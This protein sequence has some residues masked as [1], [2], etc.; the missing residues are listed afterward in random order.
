[1]IQKPKLLSF[2]RDMQKEHKVLY[3]VAVNI[4]TKHCIAHF[5]E[6]RWATLFTAADLYT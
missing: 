3:L 4:G 6:G 2:I 5:L 1:M